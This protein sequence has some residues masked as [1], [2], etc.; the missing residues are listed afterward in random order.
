MSQLLRDLPD[1]ARF[2]LCRTRKKYRL[3]RREVIKGR[4]KFI[5]QAEDRADEGTLHPS[6]YVKPVIRVQAPQP[7]RA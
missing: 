2:M 5:T 4:L 6:C 7:G 3:L 1:G